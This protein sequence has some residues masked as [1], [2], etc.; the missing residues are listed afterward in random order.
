[1]FQTQSDLLARRMTWILVACLLTLVTA[2]GGGGGGRNNT[3]APPPPPAPTPP[4]ATFS[5]TP[6]SGV[7]PL[8]IAVD[9]RQSTDANGSIVSYAWQFGPSDSGIGSV[10][11]HT[12]TDA[13]TF[14]I[15][16][17]VTDNDGDTDTATRSITVEAASAQ[18]SV[19][20]TVQ[21]LSSAAIDSDVNDR[22]SVLTDNNTFDTAQPLT[23]PVTLGGFAN[24]P[25]VGEDTGRLFA[26]GDPGDFYQVNLNGD[27][28]IVL[29]AAE[30]NADLD[31]RLWDT[32]RN[33][34]DASLGVGSTETLDVPAA[35]SY[36]I[37]VFPV[38]GASNYVMAVGQTQLTSFARAANRLSDPILPGE[39]IVKLR[40]R[41]ETKTE[42]STA[43]RY[44]IARMAAV[45]AEDPRRLQ[46][47]DL[48]SLDMGIAPPLDLPAGGRI[49][50]AQRILH[51]TLNAIKET[52]ARA[53]TEYAEPNVL[54]K[55][56][57]VP[58]DDFFSSQWHYPAINL[59]LAWD[60]TT[61]S[62][63]VIV[64]VVDTG[65]LVN[66]PDLS[67]KLVDG[68]DFIATIS[69][70]RDG[71]GPDPNPDDPGDL[72]LGGSSSFH[73]THVAGTVG[74]E[75]D[76]NLG[77][78]GV[79]W[80]TSIMPLRVLGRDGGSTFDVVQAVRYAA[81]LANAAG[82]LPDVPADIINLSLGSDF[83]SQTE[84]DTYTAAR[85]AGAIIIASAGNDSSALPSYPAAYDGVVSVSATTITNSLAGYS[86]FGPTIDVA[87][88]GGSSVTDLNGDGIGDGVI[89]AMGDDSGSGPIQFGYAVLN[90]TSMASPHVAGVAA[91]M[92]ALHP[93][94]TPAEFDLALVAGDLTDDLG[95]TGRDDQYGH[96]LINAQKAII[97][98]QL[99]ANGQGSDPGPVLA[100]SASTLNFGGFS[101][102]LGLTL[103]NIGSGQITI[104][105]VT[106]DQPWV[107]IATPGSSDG[108][109]DY[110]I[111]I[112][113]TGLADG[114]YQ[115]TLTAAS[116]ANDVN[117]TIIMQVTSLNQA[118]NAGLHYVILVDEDNA[119]AAPTIV[120]RAQNGEYPFTI[121][122]VTP[123]QYR[124]FA[125]TD[126]DDDAF[127][128]D[129]GEACGAYPSI[130][131]PEI[132]IVSGDT[133]GLV[134]E[135]AFRLNLEGAAAPTE[136]SIGMDKTE[137]IERLARDN[138]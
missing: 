32:A 73:G 74:A 124:L 121:A 12:F 112:D 29:T 14:D 48:Y 78:A 38:A 46:E 136:A 127:L 45:R 61:G 113:R 99:M 33:L 58:D 15:V 103:Q 102:Q 88:P 7:A 51:H 23:V 137:E 50:A 129:A 75:T 69:R 89:S 115:A 62:P 36:F 84:Q 35:G 96:G 95:A 31:L 72:G 109:G 70:A 25:G 128:C 120:V 133:G 39:L 20:G 65:V 10:A 131:A 100:A 44:R 80:Q 93:T 91:L 4:T 63:S 122:N 82:V 55:P 81:G 34:V 40:A 111:N 132:I 66:H 24:V 64:A 6:S 71:D 17:T 108:L 9:A 52:A 60:T 85:Q 101:N 2:C 59:P 83:A 97:A 42:R 5:L 19:S 123:G 13:G 30:A 130:D 110:L 79:A 135:S 3:P 47:P 22:L 114:A 87:A 86:N 94:M 11:Q 105:S 106:A 77:V 118:A 104:S 125:G 28:T 57:A 37:E 54:L 18:V 117:V 98:A 16:L 107:A 126:S 134:F 53:D 138:D 56:L 67:N 27:E 76:N 8:A 41:D 26:S 90:G 49:A 68:Y 21:I 92:K 119:T 43:R 1:M 116:D